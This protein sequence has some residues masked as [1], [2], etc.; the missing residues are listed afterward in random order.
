MTRTERISKRD[1]NRDEWEEPEQPRC[2]EHFEKLIRGHRVDPRFWAPPDGLTLERV[3][4]DDYTEP[5]RPGCPV[6]SYDRLVL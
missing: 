5:L 1:E 3:G 2:R 6:G 4:Y